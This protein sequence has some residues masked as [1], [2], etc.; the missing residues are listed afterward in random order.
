MICVSLTANTNRAALA[1][2][3]RNA[4]CLAAFVIATRTIGKMK[5]FAMSTIQ[6]QIAD[7]AKALAKCQQ[8][9]TNRTS[10]HR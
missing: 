8:R 10:V 1:A 6:R 9:I 3:A 4:E 5:S 2:I 7:D